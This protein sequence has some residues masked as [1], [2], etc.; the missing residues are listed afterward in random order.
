[1]TDETDIVSKGYLTTFFL[2]IDMLRNSLTGYRSI[3]LRL[4]I[5]TKKFTNIE[6]P[7]MQMDEQLKQALVSWSDAVRNSVERCHISY[8]ALLD[9][10]AKLKSENLDAYY[11][12]IIAIFC[13]DVEDV[14]KYTFE[15]HKCFIQG[16]LHEVLNKMDSFY[17]QYTKQ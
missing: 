6:K 15:I 10:V 5:D 2:D 16:T 4:N 11:E 13:P 12:K 7:A 9:T 14:A 17:E 8:K 3:I 1:M